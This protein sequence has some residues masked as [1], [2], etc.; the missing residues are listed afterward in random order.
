MLLRYSSVMFGAIGIVDWRTLLTLT[1][2]LELVGAV[3]ED[4]A[5]ANAFSDSTTNDAFSTRCDDT[6]SSLSGTAAP[7]SAAPAS[8]A[9]H[10]ISPSSLT[11]SSRRAWPT[12]KLPAPAYDPYWK[13]CRMAPIVHSTK[14]ATKATLPNSNSSIEMEAVVVAVAGSARRTLGRPAE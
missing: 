5:D 14:L 7:A 2:S 3:E 1:S 11:L 4:E 8:T 10:M 13:L 12:P 9:D 6:R